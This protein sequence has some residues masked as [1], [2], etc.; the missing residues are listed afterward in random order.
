M[1]KTLNNIDI[2]I[3]V[4]IELC[5]YYAQQKKW[6]LIPGII[7]WSLL[8]VSVVIGMFG[9]LSVGKDLLKMMLCDCQ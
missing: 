8:P 6:I 1:L 2:H 3:G 7:C 9:V 4:V 5:K